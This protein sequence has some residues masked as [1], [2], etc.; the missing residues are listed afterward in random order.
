RTRGPVASQSDLPF[1]RASNRAPIG[2]PGSC[3]VPTPLVRYL[4][5]PTRDCLGFRLQRRPGSRDHSPQPEDAKIAAGSGSRT[6][7]TRTGV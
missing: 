7:Q 2:P 6:R 1:P 3:A 5:N 4:R